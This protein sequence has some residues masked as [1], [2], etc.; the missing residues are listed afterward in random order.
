MS[1][2]ELRAGAAGGRAAAAGGGGG[3]GL[4]LTSCSRRCALS[5]CCSSRRRYRV[6][7]SSAEALQLATC[8]SSCCR[9]SLSAEVRARRLCLWKARC[10]WISATERSPV[11]AVI[12]VSVF[13]KGVEAFE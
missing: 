4:C 8:D 9:R 2:H 5:F 10:L 1:C 7:R 6:S 3:G 12:T 13:C 11:A